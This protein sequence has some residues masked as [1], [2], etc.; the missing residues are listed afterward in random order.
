MRKSEP[1]TIPK[2]GT[3][4]NN[5]RVPGYVTANALDYRPLYDM[6]TYK[7]PAGAKSEY[8]FIAKYLDPL[9]GITVDGYGNRLLI[10]GE[11]PTTLF[12]AHTDTV[13]K[14]G[15]KQ[16]IVVD[17]MGGYIYKDDKQ[18][19][20][21]DDATGIFIMLHLIAAKVPG[22]YIFHREEEMGGLGSS[23]IAESTP[24]VLSGIDRAI[25]FDRKADHSVVTHQSYGRCCSN[26]FAL[27]LAAQLG[28]DY[29]PDS[30]GLFTDTANYTDV[31][32]ECTNISVGYYSEHTAAET[33][34]LKL[35]DY[36]I[37]VLLAVQWD[38][39][40]TTRDPNA[41]DADAMAWGEDTDYTDY[42]G[43][44]SNLVHEIRTYGFTDW[45]QAYGIVLDNPDLAASLLFEAFRNPTDDV[46]P[47]I[48]PTGRAPGEEG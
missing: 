25:A 8:A 37:P 1:H 22:L 23:Y 14:R 20:G 33:Q 29:A 39:L 19:L 27:A 26:E 48:S 43:D 4:H 7:R 3:P 24:H 21:A 6:L 9:P 31:I 30:T 12:S 5:P 34:D 44:S 40:P 10:I 45:D 16:K 28:G 35:L 47:Y 17:E 36:L 13:H 18:P 42:K 11:N 46:Q 38:S 41:Y 32:P 15:G 2:P